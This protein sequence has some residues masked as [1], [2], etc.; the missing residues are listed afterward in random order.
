MGMII[1]SYQDLCGE[2]Q[3]LEWRMRDLE[4]EYYFWYRQCLNYGKKAAAPLDI[5]VERM[6]GICDQMEAYA[7]A[8]ESKQELKRDIELR[9][10]QFTGLEGKVMYK[11]VV[12]GK[13]L[14]EI[15]KD[16]GYSEIWIKK[17]SSRGQKK[18]A[19]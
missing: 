7:T 16:L 5:C 8:L 4:R 9:L 10:S 17:L 11:R 13:S 15:A 3:C 18:I 19:V 2:I 6:E 14:K 1:K 12:E